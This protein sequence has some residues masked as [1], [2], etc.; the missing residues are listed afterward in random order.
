MAFHWLTCYISYCLGCYWA[1]RKSSFLPLGGKAVIFF[2]LEKEGYISLCLVYNYPKEAGQDSS[3]FWPPNFIPF[4]F[5]NCFLFRA[6]PSAYGSSQAKGPIGAVAASLHQ[7][8]SHSHAAHAM[9]DPRSTEQ[10]Q[11]SKPCLHGY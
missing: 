10:G 4:F 9:Q 7:S 2:L 3:P 6:T 11:E 8:P 5:F 1:R